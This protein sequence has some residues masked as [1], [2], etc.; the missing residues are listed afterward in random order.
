MV[1]W[2]FLLFLA[3]ANQSGVMGCNATPTQQQCSGA[4]C[5]AESDSG[6][7]CEGVLQIHESDTEIHEFNRG[8]GSLTYVDVERIVNTE[9]NCCWKIFEKRRWSGQM[10]HVHLGYDGKPPF[11]PTSL[12]KAKC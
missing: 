7:R 2:I 1:Y 5:T 11:M 4:F 3:I 10:E 6:E 8:N 9:G 12:R